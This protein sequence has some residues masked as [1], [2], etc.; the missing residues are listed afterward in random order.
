MQHHACNGRRSGRSAKRG[1]HTIDDPEAFSQPFSMVQ[2][3]RR[4]PAGLLEEV[5][6]ENNFI[7]FGERVP[8][9]GKP[10]F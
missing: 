1:R 10:D 3:Y 8:T 2:C 9:A 4:V 6:A 5:C 7:F